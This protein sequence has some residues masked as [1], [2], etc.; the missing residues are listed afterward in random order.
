VNACARPLEEVLIQVYPNRLLRPNPA[1]NDVNYSWSYPVT[2][3][4]GWMDVARIVYETAGAAPS[5]S[6]L[7]LALAQLVSRDNILYHLLIAIG[8]FG[9]VASF[10]G[11]ILAAGRATYE[12][13]RMGYVSKKL[14]RVHPRFKTPAFALIANMLVG[15][16]A[17]VTG[18]TGDII[19]IAVFGAV[20]LYIISMI[21]LFVLRKKEPGL[22]RPFK[23]PLYPFFPAIALV[24]ATTSLFAMTFYNFNLSLIFFGIILT[25]LGW[26]KIVVQKNTLPLSTENA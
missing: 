26:F 17:L 19:T 16:A 25:G 20:I 10:H 15:I 22:P 8:L 9:L 18:K 2:F 3:D 1:L 5:D 13:G 6:P 23:T 21:S 11:I 14:G 12:F 4:P 24:L 7:P